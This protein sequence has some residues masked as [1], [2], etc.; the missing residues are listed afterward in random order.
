VDVG[1]LGPL[2]VVS[3]A[4]RIALGGPKQ[5]LVLGLLA[6]WRGRVVTVDELIDGLWP[7]GPQDQPRKTVQV[8]ITRLRRVLATSGDVIR[9]EAAGYVLDHSL[10]TFDADV[11]DRTVRDAAA[12]RDDRT[13][14]SDLRDALGL[15]RGDAFADLRESPAIVPSAVH[16]DEL[17]LTA[18]HELFEREIRVDPRHVIAELEQAV[19]AHPFDESFAAQLMTAQY[20]A[21]RQADALAT[22]QALRRRL[23]EELGLD[24][25][26]GVRELEGRI[27]RHELDVPAPPTAREPERQRRVVSV[28][29]AELRVRAD[30]SP[31]DPE[32]ELATTDPV[33]RA[34]WARLRESGGLMLAQ[35]GDLLSACFGYPS[36]ERSVERAVLA[37]LAVSQIASSA[38]N[39]E[40]RVGVDTGV[41]VVESPSEA[42]GGSSELTG[43]AGPPMRVAARLAQAGRPGEVLISPSTAAAV[44][45][46]FVLA[47]PPGAPELTGA[48][49]VVGPAE[50]PAGLGPGVLVGREAVRR[51]L[52]EIAGQATERL[53]TLA[54]T[55]PAGVGKSA[56]VGAF[57]DGLDP[58]WSAVRLH[59][60]PRQSV[61][62]LHPFRTLLPDLFA[63]DSE[64]STRAVVDAI[65]ERW[66]GA[67]PVLVVEDVHAADPSTLELLG[68]LPERLPAGL[69]VLTSRSDDPV[70]L[71]GELV[72]RVAL[73]PL[74]RA[75]ARRLATELAGP[76]RLRLATLNEI[77][78][79]SGGIPLY[80]R[81]LTRAVVDGS[82][83]GGPARVPT[84]LYDSL[85]SGLD[86][87]GPARSFA[88]RCA[89]LGES[90]SAAD[91]ALVQPNGG[92]AA[93][94][95]AATIRAGLIIDDGDGRYRFSDGLVADAAYESLLHSERAAL[96][97]R[98]AE[99]LAPQVARSEPERL[100]YH[101][102][103][104]GR[105]F[106]AAV[107]WRRA[108]ANA[109][110]R[111]RHR[112]AQQHA[113]RALELLDRLGPDGEPDA[114][115]TRRRALMNLAIGL[116]ATDHGSAE[117][118][119]AVTA[120][121]A[122][123]ADDD[124]P[125]RRIL[126]DM[127]DISNRQALGDFG[128][129]TQ[130]AEATVD[131]AEAAGDELWIAF[132][133]Q[134]LGATLV[135]RGELAIG[136]ERLQQ[137]GDY[138]ERAE[139]PGLLSAR[140]VGALWSLLGVAAWFG[141]RPA[142]AARMLARARDAVPGG[143]DFGRCLVT[144]TAAVVDQLADR[145][146]VV[147]RDVEPMW[148]LAM[149]QASDFWLTWAQ[150]V[151][152][153]SIAADGEP[154]GLAMMAE[155]IDG[156]TTRQAVPYFAYLLGS[157]SCQ[158]GKPELGLARL[159]QG[160]ETARAT[161]E[162]LWVPLL[163]LERA[164][165]LDVI[166][167]PGAAVE[168]ADMAADG[169]ARSGAALVARGVEEW[170]T[171]RSA[172]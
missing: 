28:V 142:D 101:L 164:R 135:W 44:A 26:P 138:W 41:V 171:A 73:G 127:M 140:P 33:R 102:E 85:M 92:D 96:H 8:Y 93:E 153:W 75:T 66:A 172:R 32:E 161:G 42:G 123:G 97:E 166:G 36:T 17:R 1:V 143:D 169:A 4:A 136:V 2:E 7:E 119:D 146:D 55:G 74:D 124:D 133:R 78:D 139:A 86:R 150:V 70:E 112:E 165:W 46:E 72:P 25:G 54:V 59:C 11:F 155:A 50:P 141:D 89:V 149:D 154:A 162:E 134:F 81:A 40:M 20:R 61:T 145:P 114:G 90:F 106:D 5:R 109:I 27:L 168:A 118:Q 91:L 14:I 16:L 87:L 108:S 80:V 22:Y 19:E 107:Q 65:A 62:P 30:E 6:A 132:A 110:R 156:S 94:S 68:D 63:G 39:V 69:L 170:R 15:W 60:D 37:G 105:P 159:D 51:E 24:P 56:V 157:R 3:G 84:S 117:L 129:A 77:A 38:G 88:Q 43:I 18:R 53:Y 122:G 98:V 99:G 52:V 137:A 147:R 34:A 29:A 9:S 71:A 79:R 49:L 115:G 103:A 126:L 58:T 100:A 48:A 121:R 104:A 113:R 148:S 120:A 160:L 31:L 158:L 116:Q 35:H 131:N 128:G 125:G 95:L 130:V 47:D 144:M 64:P 57:L 67:R 13:A 23:A 82:A 83:A 76:G 10:L 163:H 151:L 111:A 12:R 45:D 21:G 167:A 152:G